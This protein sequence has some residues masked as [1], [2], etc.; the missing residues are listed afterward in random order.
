VSTLKLPLPLSSPLL[1]Y[2]DLS[3]NRRV[4]TVA[5]LT[6]KTT[7]VRLLSSV[8]FATMRVSVT[9][10]LP[11]DAP[12]SML[13]EST[14]R[15]RIF[16]DRGLLQYLSGEHIAL[17]LQTAYWPYRSRRAWRGHELLRLLDADERYGVEVWISGMPTDDNPHTFRRLRLRDRLAE[18]E[19]S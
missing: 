3:A 15:L 5:I 17:S 14:I 7:P 1:D 18:L 6:H 11:V 9:G 4:E 10:C 8:E 2:W 16:R 13:W 12:L 19:A